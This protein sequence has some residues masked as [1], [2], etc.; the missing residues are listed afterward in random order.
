MTESAYRYIWEADQLII[1]TQEL[2]K[3]TNSI[4]KH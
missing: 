3:Y 2:I 1:K 4:I